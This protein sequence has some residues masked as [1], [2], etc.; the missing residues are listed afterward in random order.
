[1]ALFADMRAP[2]E[3]VIVSGTVDNAIRVGEH[4]IPNAK[5]AFA[6]MGADEVVE[7]AKTILRWIEHEGARH[8]TKRELHQA[9]RSR[10]KRVEALD[11]PLCLLLT[12]WYIGKRPELTSGGPGRKPSPTFDVNPLWA[13]Q[14]THN[15][16][17]TGM[18]PNSEDS[19]YFE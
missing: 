3:S 10:F 7:Q 1:M 11:A 5:A 12:H 14:N 16:Q 8:F 15:P 9:L 18:G 2:W 13:S 4:L 17:N 6:E 19:E